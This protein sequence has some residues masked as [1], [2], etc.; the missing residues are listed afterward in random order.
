MT[1]KKIAALS[2]SAVLALGALAGCGQNGDSAGETNASVTKTVAG[3]DDLSGAKVGVQEGT[4]GDTYVSEEVSGAEV[5]RFKRPLDAA[6]DLKNGKLDAVVIDD[7]VAKDIVAEVEGLKILSDILTEEEYAIAVPK[8][9]TELLEQINKTIKECT[10]NGT[11]Q[12]IR[13]AFIQADDDNLK[14]EAAAKLEA[15]SAPTG[16]EK[17]TMGTNAEFAPF[18]YKDD[19]N[20]ITGYDIEI[21]KQIARDSGKELVIEDMAFDSLIAALNSGKVDMVIAGMTADD[22]RKQQVDFSDTYYKASQ[23]IIVKE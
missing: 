3:A 14:Q 10:E 15:L 19:N 13:D 5:A 16:S 2:V 8:G 12:T 20:E 9:K 4:T 22:E 7:Q 18:E 11:I 1:L 17:L 6:M 23:V 21:A